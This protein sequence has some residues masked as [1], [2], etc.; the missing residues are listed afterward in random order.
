MMRL[1]LPPAAFRPGMAHA[2]ICFS[3]EIAE[4]P[5]FLAI[6]ETVVIRQHYLFVAC[7]LKPNRAV[8]TSTR[9]CADIDA[10]RALATKICWADDRVSDA[11]LYVCLAILFMSMKQGMNGF[12]LSPT[13]RD[14]MRR[15][16]WNKPAWARRYSRLLAC[17]SAP[18]SRKGRIRPQL[19]IPLATYLSASVSD[20]AILP[21]SISS[22]SIAQGRWSV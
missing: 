7:T 2:G 19:F 10:S 22:S 4:L 1:Y 20:R 17:R 6:R 14:C 15:H 5:V 13:W 12:G 3:E 18:A 8:V 16:E 11:C 21:S 9:T